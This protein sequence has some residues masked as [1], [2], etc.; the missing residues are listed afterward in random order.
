MR[1]LWLLIGLLAGVAVGTNAYIAVWFPRGW[2]LSLES[3]SHLSQTLLLIVAIVAL[4]YASGQVR[5]VHQSNQVS[6]NIGWAT[7][8]LEL[9][10]RWEGPEL[11]DTRQLVTEITEELTEKI[12]HDHPRLDDMGKVGQLG[13]EFAK[14]L[15]QMRSDDLTNYLLVMRFCGFFET[16]GLMVEQGYVP[17]DEIDRL[18]RGPVLT[19]GT[20]FRRHIDARQN[21]TGVPI[22]LFEH[23]LSLAD[24]V[25]SALEPS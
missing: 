21:E 1:W 22:G 12:G 7:L 3:A 23:A 10:R 16:V 17:L 4:L 15:D 6:L 8:L 5:A 9:D 25:K 13:E 19:V 14:R 11:L 24:R 2:A 18:F 20:C